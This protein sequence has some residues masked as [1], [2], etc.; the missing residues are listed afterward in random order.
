MGG[1]CWGRGGKAG[2][3]KWVWGGI[4]EEGADPSCRGH[5]VLGSQAQWLVE[6]GA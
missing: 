6:A 4:G 3:P 1:G 5:T 2:K